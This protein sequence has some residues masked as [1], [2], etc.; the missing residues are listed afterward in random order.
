MVLGQFDLSSTKLKV[1][2]SKKNS[3]SSKHQMWGA[4]IFL[5]NLSISPTTTT[6]SYYSVVLGLIPFPCSFLCQQLCTILF[7]LF[8]SM[9]SPP[10]LAPLASR[11]CHL[12]LVAM[13]GCSSGDATATTTL[14]QLV[15]H[16]KLLCNYYSNSTIPAPPA[17][18]TFAKDNDF[19]S[20][21]CC[22]C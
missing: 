15:Q 6:V 2:T 4:S 7:R 22:C 10:P 11:S 13:I 5:A 18:A 12:K 1:A 21:H 19:C 20:C 14:R 3:G 8:L 9:D 16:I 17:A